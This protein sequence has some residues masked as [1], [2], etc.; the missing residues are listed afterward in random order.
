M[1]KLLSGH[2]FTVETVALIPGTTELLG[3]GETHAA[4]DQGTDVVGVV[5]EYGT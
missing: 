3:G 5:L 4:S 1:R 2:R